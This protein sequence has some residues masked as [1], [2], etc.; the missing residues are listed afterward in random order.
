MLDTN[1]RAPLHRAPRKGCAAVC[2][3]T[4]LNLIPGSVHLLLMFIRGAHAK[5]VKL[6]AEACSSSIFQADVDEKGL[7]ILLEPSE[8]PLDPTLEPPSS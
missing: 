8:D 3:M 4:V 6:A 2:F 1:C 5:P 7:D